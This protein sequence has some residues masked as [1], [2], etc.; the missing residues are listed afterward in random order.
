MP[1]EK[2]NIKIVSEPEA[3]YE[4]KMI[5]RFYSFEERDK[6]RLIY[7]ASLSPE[8]LLKNLKQMVLTSFGIK[9]EAEL[10]NAPRIINLHPRP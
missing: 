1:N 10:K 9:D 2:K 4:K 5:Q 3:A 8:E 6:D 7:Y